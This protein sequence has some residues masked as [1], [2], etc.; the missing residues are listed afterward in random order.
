[1]KGVGFFQLPF[2]LEGFIMKFNAELFWESAK[3]KAE[4]LLKAAVSPREK[5]MVYILECLATEKD[6]EEIDFDRFTEEDILELSSQLGKVRVADEPNSVKVT[7]L[8]NPWNAEYQ[9]YRAI[10]G[11]TYAKNKVY[12]GDDEDDFI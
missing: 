9:H 5:A 11:I 4:T 12:R 6:P 7:P 2:H 8:L 1:M 3:K 10:R